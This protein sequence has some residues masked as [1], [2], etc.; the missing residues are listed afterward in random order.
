MI[1]KKYILDLD[2]YG[3]PV[4]ALANQLLIQQADY[5]ESREALEEN[6]QAWLHHNPFDAPVARRLTD[7]YRWRIAQLNPKTDAG[8]IQRLARKL[9]QTESRA[10]R[11]SETAF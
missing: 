1:D 9:H 6:W 7:I 10:Q 3:F 2:E 8:A 11:Y 5:G 4:T